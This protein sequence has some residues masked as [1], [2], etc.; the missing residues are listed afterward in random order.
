MQGKTDLE[1]PSLTTLLLC[2]K[3]LKLTWKLVK[4]YSTLK[5]TKKSTKG[6]QEL[7]YTR[8]ERENSPQIRIRDPFIGGR[9]TTFGS[10]NC[11]HSFTTFESRTWASMATKVC[12]LRRPKVR[13]GGRTLH[14]PPWSFLCKTSNFLNQNTTNI[15]K[16]FRK[17]FFYPS[18]KLR[19]PRNSR[20]PRKSRRKVRIPMMASSR[21]LQSPPL[22]NIRPR[23]FLKTNISCKQNSEKPL[24]RETRVLLEHGLSC[25]PGTLLDVVVIPKDFHHRDFLVSQLSNLGV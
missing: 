1:H 15:Q 4:T 7:T 2:S 10:Q 5:K 21:V 25:L 12:H 18:R 19:H 24:L 6:G 22:K 3:T 16:H 11:L 17:P 8:K 23:M 13:F 14:F 9:S 20:F